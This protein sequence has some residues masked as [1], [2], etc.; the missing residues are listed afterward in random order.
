MAQLARERER[1]AGN[2]HSPATHRPG[3]VGAPGAPL[4]AHCRDAAERDAVLAGAGGAGGA[5]DVER[6]VVD[7]AAGDAADPEVRPRSGP[8]PPPPPLLLS[9]H[10]ASLTQY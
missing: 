8:P 2:N 1:R 9:G 6:A 4:G 10:A 7:G 3:G 5:K